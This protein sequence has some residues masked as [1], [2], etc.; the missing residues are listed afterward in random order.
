VALDRAWLARAYLD[1]GEPAQACEAAGE[2]LLAAVRANSVRAATLALAPAP[3][4][5]GHRTLPEVRQY[6]EL[7]A[8][9]RPY[10]PSAG[11]E[12]AGRLR[13]GAG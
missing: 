5:L 2:A 1:A 8:A 11:R 9:A 3:H 12:A 13:G 4:L 7:V 10:L 6:A